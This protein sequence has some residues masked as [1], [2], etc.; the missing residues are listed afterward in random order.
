MPNAPA[1]ASRAVV[2]ACLLLAACSAAPSATPSADA[3]SGLSSGPAD[4]GSVEAIRTA[5]G[6]PDPVTVEVSAS[7][8][9]STAVIGPDGG[10]LPLDA[11]DGSFW[12]LS[13]PAGALTAHAEITMTVLDEVIGAPL[14]DDLAGGV[15]LEPAGLEFSEPA[16][17]TFEPATPL[18][19]GSEGP[20]SAASDGSDFVLHPM[21]PV[22]DELRLPIRHFSLFGLLKTDTQR[23]AEMIRHTARDV[24][25]QLG[26]EV[27]DLVAEARADEQAAAE[28]EAELA[29]RL[30]I[31]HDRV[32]RPMMTLAESDHLLFREA[33]GRMFG[34]A[35]QLQL[36]LGEDA[37]ERPPFDALWDELMASFLRAYA[38]F[39]DA[40]YERCVTDHELGAYIDLLRLE[41]QAQLLG[42]STDEADGQALQ[43]AADCLTFELRF[44]SSFT[45]EG[46]LPVFFSESSGTLLDHVATEVVVPATAVAG[47][48][49]EPQPVVGSLDWVETRYDVVA[50]ST[51]GTGTCTFSGEPG[52]PGTFVVEELALAPELRSSTREDGEIETS[53]RLRDVQLT[54]EPGMPTS[55]VTARCP[56]GTETSPNEA[57]WR[58]SWESAR[59]HERLTGEGAAWLLTGWEIEPAGGELLATLTFETRDVL[60]GVTT[61]SESTTIELRHAP[62]AA[63]VASMPPRSSAPPRPSAPTPTAP[64][65]SRPPGGSLEN[66][67]PTE[68]AG[69]EMEVAV[70]SLDDAGDSIDPELV[71]ELRSRGL[72]VDDAEVGA[73]NDPT[74]RIEGFAIALLVPG[75]GAGAL[76]DAAQSATNTTYE[77]RR[78]GGRSV[79]VADDGVLPAYVYVTGD[80]LFTVVAAD[81]QAAATIL[82]ALP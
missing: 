39:V 7:E 11:P 74:G 13:V 9:S 59:Q 56:Y 80:V 19:P 67:L 73:I 60:G 77:A 61:L 50:E 10:V 53:L 40:T 49:G 70:A 17:L 82:S 64:G 75:A 37:L 68:I 12:E 29:S 41:R 16:T 32:V 18:E 22:A 66:L 62:G 69:I 27:A 58:S 43:R 36:L 42:I 33:A 72:A 30:R 65:A 15:R 24:E 57:G 34:W 26:Q 23:R 35:R 46:E 52:E 1:R 71:T 31:Y 44:D 81:D 2:A 55:L 28:L 51:L 47:F 14:G 20:F 76:T 25:A 54:L 3:S 5:Y 38:N 79:L 4:P 48:A 6:P 78:V 8:V 63:P 21:L 45:L